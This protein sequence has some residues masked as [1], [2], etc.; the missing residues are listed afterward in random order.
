MARQETMYA[1]F[2]DVQSGRMTFE[3]FEEWVC[4]VRD[5]TWDECCELYNVYEP[6]D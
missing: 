2:L 1:M 3:Q 5:E 6:R 4:S